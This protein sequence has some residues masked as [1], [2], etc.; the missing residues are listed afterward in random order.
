M[1][2]DGSRI[3]IGQ[4]RFTPEQTLFQA[5][6]IQIFDLVDGKW[7]QVGEDIIGVRNCDVVG[8]GFDL[9]PDG[10]RIIVGFPN[11]EGMG[12][13]GPECA[14]DS[15]GGPVVGFVRLYQVELN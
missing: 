12:A 11:A 14:K 8:T 13:E 5:G 2:D 10:S 7:T 1:S 9:S 4:A 3:A 15:E 6:R